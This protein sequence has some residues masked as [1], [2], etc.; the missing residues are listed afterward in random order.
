MSRL[1]PEEEKS[2]RAIFDGMSAKGRKRI[3]NKGYDEWDPFQKPKDPLDMRIDK[4]R[5][6]A[7]KLVKEFLQTCS[8]EKYS[9]AYGRGAWDICVGIIGDSERHTAMY[10]FSCWYRDFLGNG[11]D[12]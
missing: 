3:L 5:N 12:E 4:N 11:K 10:E 6:T 9:N 8:H 2:K 7:V 1:S